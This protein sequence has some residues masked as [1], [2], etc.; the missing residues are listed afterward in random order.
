MRLKKILWGTLLVY[1]LFHLGYSVLRYNVFN[2]VSS[3][4]FNRAYSEAKEWKQGLDSGKPSLGVFHPPLYYLV[5]L[6][7]DSLLGSRF[8]L[9][10]F[11]YFLQFLLFPAA[12]V[13]MVRSAWLGP[14]PAPWSAYGFAALL[15]ANFQPFLETLAQ[16]KVE[17]IEFFLI[18]LAI[19]ALRKGADRLCG[20][21]LAFAA[22]L[23]YLPAILLVH[24]LIKR[25]KRVLL[26]A[27]AGG[28]IIALLLW[29]S[30]GGA[31]FRSG[32]LRNTADLLLSE[33]YEG[34]RPEVSVEF[35]TLTGTVNRWLAR[36]APGERFMKYI[37]VGSYMPVPRAGLAHGI[38]FGLQLA[39]GALWIFLLHRKWSRPGEPGQ[40]IPRL[41]EISLSLVMIF[42]FSRCSRVHYAILLLPSFIWT[43]LLMVQR[44][45]L[46]G[47]TG[48]MLFWV[49]Y[50][51]AGM[52][53]PGGLLNHL[54]PH[55]VW[56]QWYSAMYLWYSVPFYGYLLLALSVII[57]H[58]R[59]IHSWKGLSNGK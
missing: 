59:V 20:G 22:N 55:P 32:S 26:G 19:W 35:Q 18:G 58:Q 46:F 14:E 21:L 51:A 15:A 10:L 54:P 31:L 34:T 44:P 47:Q 13:L 23:K 30:L 50:A 49:G 27:L 33:K 38:A 56:G 40:W 17:G 8:P 9:T 1:T 57:C 37:E 52:I 43:G 2:G 12:I 48:R 7:M 53:V 3:G 4:D 6:R 16:H 25:E 29:T 28:G 45:D 5:L 41:Q 42:L 39:A 36:P 24:F 11:F